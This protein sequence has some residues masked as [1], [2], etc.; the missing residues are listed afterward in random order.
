GYAHDGGSYYRGYAYRAARSYDG[1]AYGG[2]GQGG[3]AFDGGPTPGDGGLHPP[4]QGPFHRQLNQR[5][6]PRPPTPPSAPNRGFMSC[7]LFA[8]E[9]HSRAG[10][11]HER[12]L[13]LTIQSLKVS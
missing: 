7:Q 11:A 4:S 10:I 2:Y 3:P 1:Y 5:P 12:R 9:A 13:R 8:V 6:P